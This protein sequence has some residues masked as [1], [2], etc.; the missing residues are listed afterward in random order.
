MPFRDKVRRVFHRSSVSAAPPLKTN[1]NGVKIEY[2]RRNEVPNSKFRGPFDPE[3]QRRLAAW[4]FQSAM[5]ERPRSSDLSL[6]PCTSL[7]DYL[8]PRQGQAQQTPG[9]ND[10]DEEMAPDQVRGNPVPVETDPMDSKLLSFF[11]FPFSFFSFSL[12]SLSVC[13]KNVSDPISFSYFSSRPG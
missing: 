4:S 3:H 10:D 8:R 9:V 1:R 5:A 6:S 11:L 7:P 13:V 12:L 2:Y